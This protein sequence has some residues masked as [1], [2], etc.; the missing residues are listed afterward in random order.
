[1]EGW[2]GCSAA[3]EV[4]VSVGEGASVSAGESSTTESA[5]A[6]ASGPVSWVC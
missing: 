6:D 2:A 5:G 1:M 4:G 3:A